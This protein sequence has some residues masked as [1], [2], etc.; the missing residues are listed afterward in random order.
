MSRDLAQKLT[1]SFFKREQVMLKNVERDQSAKRGGR[2]LVRIHLLFVTRRIPQKWPINEH[3]I[4]CNDPLGI[5]EHSP[6]KPTSTS[7][8]MS[9]IF[10][11]HYH[12]SQSKQ[13][14]MGKPLVIVAGTLSCMPYREYIEIIK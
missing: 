5:T 8:H 1:V 9:S 13:T 10:F 11:I 12:T 6:A 3:R 4:S 14:V 7:V 2:M